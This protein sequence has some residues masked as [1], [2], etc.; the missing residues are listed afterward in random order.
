MLLGAV[1][2]RRKEMPKRVR[3]I[4]IHGA[5]EMTTGQL[6]EELRYAGVM[7]RAPGSSTGPVEIVYVPAH[8]SRGSVEHWAGQQIQRMATFTI[9]AEIVYE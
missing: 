2:Y 5:A 9:R 6:L 1:L 7:G 3:G 8:I 4:R